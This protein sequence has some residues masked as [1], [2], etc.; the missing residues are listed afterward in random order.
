[1]F[2]NDI[3]RIILRDFFCFQDEN[4]SEDDKTHLLQRKDPKPK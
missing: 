1:M 4:K 2:F 3:I